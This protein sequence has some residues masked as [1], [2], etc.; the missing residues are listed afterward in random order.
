MTRRH[1]L[2][3]ACL[4]SCQRLRYRQLSRAVR[5]ENPGEPVSSRECFYKQAEREKGKYGGGQSH[6]FVILLGGLDCGR[7]EFSNGNFRVLHPYLP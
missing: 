1:Q 6:G 7:R 4:R 2:G 5:N 3:I